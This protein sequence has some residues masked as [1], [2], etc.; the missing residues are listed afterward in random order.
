MV[1]K[2][3]VLI[4]LSGQI[5]CLEEQ[6]IRREYSISNIKISLKNKILS[7]RELENSCY[8]CSHN[9]YI[10]YGDNSLDESIYYHQD[11]IDELIGLCKTY[12]DFV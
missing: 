6:G 3:V 11:E 8:K 1:D 7:G 12:F 4:N 9:F 5:S 10:L 2:K